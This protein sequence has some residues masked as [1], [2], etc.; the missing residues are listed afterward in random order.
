MLLLAVLTGLLLTDIE[1]P[2]RF[3]PGT[4]AATGTAIAAEAG[5]STPGITVTRPVPSVSESLSDVQARSPSLQG[6]SP[7]DRHIPFRRIPRSADAGLFAPQL[8]L[9]LSPAAPVTDAPVSR[10]PALDD[11]FAGLGN[12]DAISVPGG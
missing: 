4:S 6:S 1:A 2:P 3:V 12:F 8:S 5:G 11:S 9:S 10:A 7:R